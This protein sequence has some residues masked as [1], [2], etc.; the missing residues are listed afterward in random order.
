MVQLVQTAHAGQQLVQR[1]AFRAWAVRTGQLQ[2]TP[3]DLLT[4]GV[5]LR[6]FANV[7]NA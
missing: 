6:F 4:D 7:F 5:R 2:R 3:L 1:D